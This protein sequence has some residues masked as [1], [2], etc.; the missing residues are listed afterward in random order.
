MIQTIYNHNLEQIKNPAFH[1]YAARYAEIY[2]NF[3]VQISQFGLE[4]EAVSSQLEDHQRLAQFEAQ[5][6]QVRNDHKSLVY[7]HISPSCIACR[8]AIDSETFFISLRCHRDCFYCFNPNQEGYQHFLDHSRNPA[9]ELEQMAAQRR[10]LEHIALTG[11]EPMLHPQ[12]CLDFFR[13]ARRLYPGSHTRLYTSGDQLTPGYL[14]ALKE[15]GLDE[16]RISVRMHDTDKAHHHTM[17]RLALSRE[18]IPHVMIEMPVLPGTYEAMLDLLEECEK[19]GVE[20]INLLELC[21]PINNA[22]EFRRRGYKIKTPPFR[23]LYNYWYAGGL[24]I[25]GSEEVCLKLIEYAIGHKLKLGLHYCSLENKHSGQ[26]YQQNASAKLDF[27][28]YFSPNDFFIKSAKVFG[29]EIQPVKKALLK[30]RRARFEHFPELDYLVF[31]PRYISQL[32][33][34]EVEVGLSYSVVETREDGRYLRELKIART[35][36]QEYNFELDA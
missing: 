21:F 32:Q 7:R 34:L 3:L 26:I 15:A 9:Q 25:A 13:T 17:Q 10:V 22:E 29:E 6:V 31:H 27:Y 4:L 8:E 1:Q 16:I 36:P 20:G 14:A 19:I 28:S 18:Y 12:E 23:V 35:T 5:G 24:P 2:Q 30:I 33:P 11:G